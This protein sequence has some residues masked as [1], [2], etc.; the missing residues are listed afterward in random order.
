MSLQPTAYSVSAQ[1]TDIGCRLSAGFSLIEMAVVIAVI[2]L[3]AGSVVLGSSVVRAQQARQVLQDAATYRNAMVLFYQSYGDYPGDF[4]TATAQWGRADGDSDTA[5]NCATPATDT[6]SGGKAT[7]NG[8]GDE[9][10]ES[11][12]YESFRAWQ[13]MM[14]ANMITGF[15]T[16]VYETGGTTYAVPG[17]NSPVSTI[18]NG[19]FFIDSYGDLASDGSRFDGNYDNVLIFGLKTTNSYPTTAALSGKEAYQLDLKD[20]DGYP[21]FGDI[22][23]WKNATHST[24]ATT[25]V[26]STARYSKDEDDDAC[27][28]F[29]LSTFEGSDEEE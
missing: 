29:F 17:T 7:C 23:A 1:K 3:M 8:D 14:A 12:N 5:S 10:I 20:D 9:Y 18:K 13:H 27:G 4:S 2:A 21:G 26:A 24:C 6:A 15:F 28:L 22:R 16:G 25:D 11:A 19:T